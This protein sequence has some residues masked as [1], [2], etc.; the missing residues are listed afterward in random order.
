LGK[1]KKLGGHSFQISIERASHFQHYQLIFEFG[2]FCNKKP[3]F[4]RVSS[5]VE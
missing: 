5:L 3:A 4:M 1:N 2:V